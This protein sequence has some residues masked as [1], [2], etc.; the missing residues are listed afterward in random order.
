MS[1]TKPVG[2]EIVKFLIDHEEDILIGFGISGYI[3]STVLGIAA[4]PEALRK[5]EE[6][7][8]KKGSPL[9]KKEII[10]VCWKCY[11]KTAIGLTASTTCV[12]CARSVSA[13]KNAA[14]AAAYK[15]SE[16]AF[17]EYK[18]KVIEEIGEKKEREIVTDISKD[19]VDANPPTKQNIIVTG[20]GNYLCCEP[21]SKRYFYSDIEEVK[22]AFNNLNYKMI[23]DWSITLNDLYDELGLEHTNLGDD[24]GWTIENGPLGFEPDYCGTSIENDFVPGGVP[25]MIIGYNRMPRST[26]DMN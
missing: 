16:T 13:N 12:L 8:K 24:L 14:M 17:T 10:K 3:S 23:N 26:Y 15:L 25:C 21:I 7:E 5:I 9:T 1:S 6:T 4:T 20:K 11:I 2:K 22:T 18:D 19:K